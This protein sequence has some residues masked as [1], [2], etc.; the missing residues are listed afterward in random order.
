MDIPM[1]VLITLCGED[2]IKKPI[3]QLLK[4]CA[5]IEENKENLDGRI[6]KK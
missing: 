3:P 1:E 6:N 4:E 5:G 2:Q